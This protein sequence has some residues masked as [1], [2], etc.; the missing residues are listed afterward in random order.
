MASTIPI[1]NKLISYGK[2]SYVNA[3][4]KL[5]HDKIVELEKRVEA[6]ENP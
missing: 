2:S 1:P 6:L 3:Y 5:M 4:F